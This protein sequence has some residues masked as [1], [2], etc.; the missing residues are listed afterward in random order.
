MSISL[1]R[2]ISDLRNQS[3]TSKY[4]LSFKIQ[5]QESLLGQMTLYMFVLNIAGCR[6]KLSNTPRSSSERGVEGKKLIAQSK[7]FG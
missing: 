7:S 4:F 3:F 2:T 6:I 1:W 5:V